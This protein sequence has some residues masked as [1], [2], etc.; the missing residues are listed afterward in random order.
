M[1]SPLSTLAGYKRSPLHAFFA[2]YNRYKG[3]DTLNLIHTGRIKKAKFRS[4][5]FVNMALENA[6]AVRH[7]YE[8]DFSQVAALGDRAIFVQFEQLI[9]SDIAVKRAALRKILKFVTADGT[10]FSNGIEIALHP[11]AEMIAHPPMH[12]TALK[13]VILVFAALLDRGFR[14]A[15]KLHRPPPAAD[16]LT[17]EEAWTPVLK[18]RYWRILEGSVWRLGGYMPEK[19]SRFLK[20]EQAEEFAKVVFP[21]KYEDWGT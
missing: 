8:N 13:T 14:H 2:E 7:W 20:E 12:S 1:E 11:F 15:E 18:K 9:S 10:H 21:E 16:E 5:N 19:S 6:Y 4:K 3:N 17:F